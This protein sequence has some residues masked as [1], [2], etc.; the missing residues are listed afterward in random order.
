VIE[1]VLAAVLMLML[2]AAAVR[3]EDLLTRARAL[4][5][6]AAYE[7]ALSVLNRLRRDASRSAVFPEVDRYRA[8]CLLALGRRREAEEAIADLLRAE[9][10][11]RPAEAEVSPRIRMAFVEVRRALLPAIVQQRYADGKAAYQRRDFVEA[12]ALFRDVIEAI[13]DQELAP[14]E[15]PRSLADLSLLAEG[16]HELSI[17]AMTPRARPLAMAPATVPSPRPVTSDPATSLDRVYSSDDRDV[18]APVIVRQELPPM[19]GGNQTRLRASGILDLVIGEDGTV[20]SAAM[21]T[22]IA[23][24]YDRLLLDAVKEWRFQPAMRHG[25][26]VRFR[27]LMHI[28]VGG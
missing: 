26:A 25:K 20:Q 12:E 6:A 27:K 17:A 5:S 10:R 24:A 15:T 13:E 4:Y 3:A 11:Y 28:T 1:R 8:F 23:P 14:L 7:D 19:P 21:S 22:P 16:F 18:I 2:S 9:P